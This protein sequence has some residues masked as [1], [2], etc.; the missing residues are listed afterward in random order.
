MDKNSFF[1]QNNDKYLLGCWK[2]GKFLPLTSRPWSLNTYCLPK[3]WYRTGCLDLRVGDSSAI[4]S[5]VKSWLYQDML[6][7]PQE[8]VTFR[9]V[10]LGGLGLHCVKTMAM[11]MLKHTFLSEPI[12]PRFANNQ[13][14]Q[15]LY[16]WH[17]LEERHFSDPG[18]PPYYSSTFF[19]LIKDV[20]ENT[21]LNVA[22]V[23]VKQWYQLLLERGVTHT[24]DNPDTP[25]VLINTRVEERNPSLDLSQSYSL[26]RVF[27]LAPEQKSFIF[28]MMQSLLPTRD[29][30]ARMRKVQSSSCIH[31]DGVTDSTEHLLTCTN[32]TEVSSR[33]LNC[34]S[35]Y[36]PNIT[37]KNIVIL[38]IPVSESLELPIIWLVSSCMSFIWEQRVMGKVARLEQCRAELFAKLML[39]RD[40]KWRHYTLHNSA[41]LLED[42]LNLHFS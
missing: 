32:S 7:K 3:L 4:T 40:T 8:M 21:P 15:H 5:S 29:R 18:R 9:Q 17:V 31:C 42:M 13:Y 37:P 22:W 34:L 27:G 2:S 1:Q 11:A 16:K 33:L 35:S 10:E 26:S 14:H 25:P 23:T 41:V 24:S 20:K 30:L 39:L 6:E 28:K 38:D 12:C 36:F 19:N